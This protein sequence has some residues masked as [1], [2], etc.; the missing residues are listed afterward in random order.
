[1]PTELRGQQSGKLLQEF[2]AKAK[3]VS[4]LDYTSTPTE[5]QD[6]HLHLSLQAFVDEICDLEMKRVLFIRDHRTVSSTLVQA[7]TLE[8]AKNAALN[9]YTGV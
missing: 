5:I 4:Q 9:Q 2:V 7:L 8:A 3:R 6:L 1:M